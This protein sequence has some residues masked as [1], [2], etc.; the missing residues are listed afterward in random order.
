MTLIILA[1]NEKVGPYTCCNKTNM[2]VFHFSQ[3][4]EHARAS[5]FFFFWKLFAHAHPLYFSLLTLFV[6]SRNIR[7]QRKETQ[8]ILAAP[9]PEHSLTFEA[10]KL[11]PASTRACTI[12]V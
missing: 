4:L 9:L 3:A 1:R 12:D 10:S 7:Y 8:I 6:S 11:A 2:F 5:E